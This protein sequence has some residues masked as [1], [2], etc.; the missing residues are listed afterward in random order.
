MCNC[1]KTLN[2][3]YADSCAIEYY[4]FSPLLALRRNA[5]NLCLD[6]LQDV[7]D[8]SVVIRFEDEMQ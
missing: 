8:N 7:E 2:E 1:K 3:F 5:Q 6:V 4:N